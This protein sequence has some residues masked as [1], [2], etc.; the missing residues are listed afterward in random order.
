MLRLMAKDEAGAPRLRTSARRSQQR[1]E[2]RRATDVIRDIHRRALDFYTKPSESGE[3]ASA[4]RTE[5]MYHRMMLVDD[6]TAERVTAE[7]IREIAA[8]FGG[9]VELLTPALRLRVRQL[10]LQPL[11]LEE[12]LLLPDEDWRSYAYREG[13]ARLDVRQEPASALALVEHRGVA[14]PDTMPE[15][16]LR[17]LD[18]A[19]RWDRLDAGW[20]EQ[21][22]VSQAPSSQA[23]ED[24]GTHSAAKS[25]LLFRRQ[26]YAAAM[27][28]A[29]GVV[30]EMYMAVRRFARQQNKLAGYLRCANYAL[31]SRAAYKS[32]APDRGMLLGELVD[33]DWPFSELG[34]IENPALDLELRRYAA[35]TWRPG[36]KLAVS[37]PLTP[38]AFVPDPDWLRRVAAAH[39]ADASVD[40]WLASWLAY[41]G[42]AP[43]IVELLNTK[44]NEF[45]T[46]LLRRDFKVDT[47]VPENPPDNFDAMLLLGDNPEMQPAARYALREA[48]RTHRDLYRLAELAIPHLPIVPADLQPNVFAQASQLPAQRIALLVEYADRSRVLG[49]I[50]DAAARER[51]TTEALGLMSKSFARWEEAFANTIHDNKGKRA[52]PPRTG[53]LI[54]R[55]SL[56][57]GE[58]ASSGELTTNVDL[59][60]RIGYDPSYLGKGIEIPAPKL[61][62]WDVHHTVLRYS[63]FEIVLSRKSR[64]PIYAAA[65][66]GGK[67]PWGLEQSVDVDALC[68]QVLDPRLQ[69]EDQYLVAPSALFAFLVAP[70]HVLYGSIEKIMISI[71]D[72]R[73]VP[74]HI[75]LEPSD[76]DRLPHV[77]LE[78]LWHDIDRRITSRSSDPEHRG[79][80]FTG[81]DTRGFHWKVIATTVDESRRLSAAAFTMELH[82]EKRKYLI[83]QIRLRDLES[84]LGMSFGRLAYFDRLGENDALLI[85]E[86][87]DIHF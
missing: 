31:L 61:G 22:R 1:S 11:T 6:T 86:V 59:E 28:V 58:M 64:L 52:K 69:R 34:E 2:E 46:R 5:A 42:T 60:D 75:P 45:A 33:A 66:I 87:G 44:A 51:P 79:V 43:T 36:G 55:P 30:I 29:H 48:F 53:Q 49:R 70:E 65:N 62:A 37:P 83:H 25:L 21:V 15:W 57:P 67:R 84:R 71:G 27:V 47:L 63:R 12:A 16:H 35:L 32:T 56:P 77:S 80:L 19:V 3:D 4:A 38:Y 76:P 78:P 24:W 8:S 72:T 85:D 81:A 39:E 7:E 17:A 82:P 13:L 23:P 68:A 74:N 20:L 54:Q 73:F 50:L 9:D 14:D 26:A 10:T 41:T 18:A 40:A